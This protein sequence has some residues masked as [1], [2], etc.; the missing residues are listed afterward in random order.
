MINVKNIFS[1]FGRT[2]NNSYRLLGQ[3]LLFC[4]QYKREETHSRD[5]NSGQEERSMEPA[6]LCGWYYPT[7]ILPSTARF[8][9]EMHSVPTVWSYGE[10]CGY[11]CSPPTSILRRASLRCGREEGWLRSALWKDVCTLDD[12]GFRELE[13]VSSRRLLVSVL[14]LAPSCGCC[15][16]ALFLL[17]RDETERDS[18]LFL[19]HPPCH[20]PALDVGLP[21]SI[22][23]SHSAVVFEGWRKRV[24]H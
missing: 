9:A 14:P 4:V 2:V 12:M 10:I 1:V 18:A 6:C 15:L 17:D 19:L 13:P 8:S 22:T 3:I 20:T 7:V 21:I 11:A 5:Q 23:L 24:R 16:P